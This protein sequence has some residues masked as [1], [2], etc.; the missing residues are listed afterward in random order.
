MLYGA[1]IPPH[2]VVMGVSGSG[3]TT[4]ATRLAELLD[5]P[6]AEADDMHPPANV[7]K[8]SA[9]APLTDA[10][11][12]PWLRTVRD[13]LSAQAE[14]CRSAVVTCSAL[15]RVYRDVLREAAC[16]DPVVGIV[17]EFDASAWCDLVRR[18][19]TRRGGGSA[20]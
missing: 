5:R 12:E 15:R 19:R 7:A 2:L 20:R 6:F 17:V 9:G 8:M 10:D 1:S 13:W 14:Q 18:P 4:V 11:R 3:K 16:G